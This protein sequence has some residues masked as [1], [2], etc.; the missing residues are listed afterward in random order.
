MPRSVAVV[1]IY[2]VNPLSNVT[3]MVDNFLLLR[4]LIS[5]EDQM[6]LFMFYLEKRMIVACN[7]LGKL[8]IDAA[9]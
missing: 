7:M 6:M 2:V 8:D 1:N 3:L 9:K 4:T 5:I